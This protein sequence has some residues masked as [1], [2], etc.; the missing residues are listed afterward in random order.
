MLVDAI[1]EAKL[2]SAILSERDGIAGALPVG[3]IVLV[4]TSALLL[5][6]QPQ[7]QL[8]AYALQADARPPQNLPAAASALRCHLHTGNANERKKAASPKSSSKTA[9]VHTHR[10][11]E[12]M[13][14][15]EPSNRRKLATRRGRFLYARLRSA[16]RDRDHE[17]PESTT[18]RLEPDA[19]GLFRGGGKT[20]NAPRAL[21]HARQVE[22]S[23]RL[24][25]RS[26]VTI[27]L[28][29]FDVC[30]RKNRRRPQAFLSS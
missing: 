28:M 13:A 6:L 8:Q 22:G 21:V 16:S 4:A 1:F 10:I 14:A 2:T 9:R 24:A 19:R 11:D 5:L 12:I 3:T 7:L 30:R 27:G 29:T 15:R 26:R 20:N 18:T 17:Q 23:V 25:A